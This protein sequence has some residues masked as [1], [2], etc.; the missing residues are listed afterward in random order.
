[1]SVLDASAL[2]AYLFEEPGAEVVA[3]IIDTAWISS[4]NL[5]EVLTRIAR[6]GR[7]PA[8]FA[9]KLR[10][11]NVQV[12]PF[13]AKDTFHCSIIAIAGSSFEARRAGK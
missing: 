3:E 12:A 7:A 5:A 13:L 9:A 8:E 1:M 11:T 6:D 4:V 2:L 10:Q